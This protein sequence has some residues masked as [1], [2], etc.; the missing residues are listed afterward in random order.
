MKDCCIVCGTYD[1]IKPW[2]IED[3]GPICIDCAYK[4]GMI[5]GLE[6]F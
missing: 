4:L 1:Y 3:L 2:T 6:D 5:H